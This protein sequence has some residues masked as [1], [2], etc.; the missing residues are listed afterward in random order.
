MK[1]YILTNENKY[2]K[3]RDHDSKVL[4]D[5]LNTSHVKDMYCIYEFKNM[6]YYDI[7]KWNYVYDVE[8]PEDVIF[9]KTYKNIMSNK[10]ILSNFRM[11]KDMEE[12]NNKKLCIHALRSNIK[13]IKYINPKFQNFNL[14]MFFLHEFKYKY[15]KDRDYFRNCFKDYEYINNIEPFNILEYI[16][17][18]Y[19]SWFMKHICYFAIRHDPLSLKYI[20]PELKTKKLC[21]YVV[22]KNGLALQF[23]DPKFQT[24]SICVNAINSNP[25]AI[26]FIK[27]EFKVK[28]N[29]MCNFAVNKNG[30]CIKHIENE[31]QT[32]E[33]CEVAILQNPLSIQYI[34]KDLQTEQMCIMAVKNNPNMLNYIKPE[35]QTKNVCK[36]VCSVID[37][38]KD[39]KLKSDILKKIKVN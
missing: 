9:Y 4:N 23:V 31:L 27:Y 1:Y 34:H 22:K 16:N 13:N 7:L 37:L 17:P 21:N 25:N 38:I 2:Y 32:K 5:G 15:S 39:K 20:R 14:C 19:Q 28:Y 24:Q 10:I 36:I 12:W 30:L 8:I 33:L 26:E 18:K 6:I 11:V 3:N 29:Y 35:L